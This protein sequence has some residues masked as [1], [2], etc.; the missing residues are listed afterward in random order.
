[1]MMVAGNS[2]G[3]DYYDFSDNG[4]NGSCDNNYGEI[5]LMAVNDSDS[6]VSPMTTETYSHWPTYVPELIR[7]LIILLI[8]INWTVNAQ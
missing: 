3:C 5:V 6:D 8:I 4:N 2:S 1:M 7:E